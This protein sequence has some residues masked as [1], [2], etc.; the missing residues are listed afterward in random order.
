[1]TLFLPFYIGK[2]ENTVCL[3]KLFSISD[4]ACDYIF[5]FGLKN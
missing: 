1:M 3:Q 4:E 2:I 5:Q